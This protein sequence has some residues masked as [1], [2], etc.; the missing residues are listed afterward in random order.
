MNKLKYF[1][2]FDYNIDDYLPLVDD[3]RDILLEY[4]QKYDLIECGTGVPNTNDDLKSHNGYLQVHLIFPRYTDNVPYIQVSVTIRD[5]KD[6]K[7]FAADYD[8]IISRLEKFKFKVEEV[9]YTR[10]QS[11]NLLCQ[12]NIFK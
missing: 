9:R 1:E 12:F 4:A 2:N 10:N 5:Y 3:I 6:A 11:Y 7:N 8:V